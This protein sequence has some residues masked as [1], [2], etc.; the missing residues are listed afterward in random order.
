MAF[1]RDGST[2]AA[3]DEQGAITLWNAD[4]A[5]SIGRI[6]GDAAEGVRSLAFGRGTTL[7]VIRG[8]GV[9]LWDVEARRRLGGP[10]LGPTEAQGLAFSPDGSKLA[11]ANA[12]G[13]ITL[14]NE[15]SGSAFRMVGTITAGAGATLAFSPNGELLA[16]A[17]QREYR[18]VL[19][20]AATYERVGEL[21]APTAVSH[22]NQV[23]SLAFSPDGS[24]LA[25]GGTFTWNYPPPPGKDRSNVVLWDMTTWEPRGTPL[26]GYGSEVAALAF[27][28]DGDSLASASSDG[29][30]AMWHLPTRQRLEVAARN[31]WGNS[32]YGFYRVAI[33]VDGS[34]IATAGDR[35]TLW[36]VRAEAWRERACGIANRNLDPVDE[37]PRFMGA[38]PYEVTCPK[39]QDAD[40]P[41]ATPYGDAST[42]VA[43]PSASPA[44]SGATFVAYAATPKDGTPQTLPTPSVTI[45]SQET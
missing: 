10:L 28:K 5:K 29:I 41:P 27:G 3:G 18:I 12:D 22:L 42:T 40:L 21:R 30:I 1:A 34:T 33:S 38:Q 13:S 25:A 26:T 24:T 4:S 14:W 44:L 45:W 37:W 17:S 43:T 36:D 19:W 20:D 8:P 2:V 7:A 11:I 6:N 16:A 35:V 9:E 15:T 23:S 31:L 32:G 39:L